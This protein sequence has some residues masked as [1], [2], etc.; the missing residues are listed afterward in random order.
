ML[1]RRIRERVLA[2]P[3]T[4]RAWSFF[5]A[6]GRGVF[7]SHHRVRRPRHR[8]FTVTG[9]H[10]PQSAMEIV[11]TEVDFL[12]CRSSVALKA[13]YIHVMPRISNVFQVLLTTG[14]VDRRTEECC[15]RR[16]A[17]NATFLWGGRNRI[18]VTESG[19]IRLNSLIPRNTVHLCPVERFNSP[20]SYVCRRK[21]FLTIS[22]N[23][24]L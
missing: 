8:Q 16:I 22:C 3:R 14:N 18:D 2:T 20:R 6:K 11:T 19:S 10:S 12:W 17:P 21:S 24:T 15:G 13:E 7:V 5:G 9:R 4:M 1:K 23:N